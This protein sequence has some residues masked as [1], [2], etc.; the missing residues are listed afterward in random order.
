MPLAYRT[1]SGSR[2]VPAARTKPGRTRRARCASMSATAGRADSATTRAVR[3]R[4]RAAAASTSAAS[5]SAPAANAGASRR[6]TLLHVGERVGIPRQV[7]RDRS[8]PGRRR[9]RRPRRPS[10][11]SDTVAAMARRASP[12]RPRFT[13]ATLGP[14]V[15]SS[16]RRTPP[17]ITRCCRLR[18]GQHAQRH[19]VAVVE[20]RRVAAHHVAALRRRHLPWHGADVPRDDAPPLLDR[21]GLGDGGPGDAGQSGADGRQVRIGVEHGRRRRR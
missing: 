13:A 6:T 10:S 8:A 16:R 9:R 12:V 14:A 4:T 2:R 7:I 15:S 5:A 21:A 3:A 1:R 11:S 19:A 18:V 17:R 20:Q